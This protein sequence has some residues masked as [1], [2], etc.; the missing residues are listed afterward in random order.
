VFVPKRFATA[1]GA[2]VGEAD[3]D[4][5]LWVIFGTDTG[6][7]GTTTYFVTE[8]RLRLERLLD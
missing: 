6:F 7:E 8:L 2:L 3:R 1:G 5:N 4:G